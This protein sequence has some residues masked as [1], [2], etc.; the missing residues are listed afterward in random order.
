[1]FIKSILRNGTLLVRGPAAEAL[2]V[3]MMGVQA[4][5]GPE[6]RAVCAKAAADNDGP[7]RDHVNF[8]RVEAPMTISPVRMY[9]VPQSWFDALYDKQGVTG[10]YILGFGSLLFF[11]SKEWWVI[12]HEFAAGVCLF[13]TWAFLL[14]KLSPMAMEY[15]DKDIKEEDAKLDAVRSIPMKMMEETIVKMNENIDS[16]KHNH[17]V[18]DAKKEN[19]ALQ[20]EAAY[21][22]RLVDAHTQVKQ[23]LDYHLHTD[24][25]K[26][27]FEH[28]HMVD[29]IVKNVRSSITPASEAATLKQCLV[30]LKGIAAR[31]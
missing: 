23:K 26:Q 21:R 31:T 1:M 8:P 9:C 30:D 7:E 28:K 20:L 12:E 3:R 17:L 13:T 22:Q 2:S 10:P 5:I 18:Y 11:I 27:N 25:V 19:I 14:K 29:W 15:M 4:R 24:A 6:F 16:A